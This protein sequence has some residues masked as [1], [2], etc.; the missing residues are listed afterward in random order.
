MLKRGN[1]I[2]NQHQ[3]KQLL[4]IILTFFVTGSA[5]AQK[6]KIEYL[7]NQPYDKYELLSNGDTLTFY[8]LK[9][10]DNIH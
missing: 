9:S 8:L 2:Y 4:I 3:M 1:K 6:A 7:P 5:F 10:F